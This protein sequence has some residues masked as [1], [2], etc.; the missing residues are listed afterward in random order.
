MSL[1]ISMHR[2]VSS[3]DSNGFTSF[4][5]CIPFFFFSF[6]SLIVMARTSETRLNNN[7]KSGNPCLVLDLRWDAFSVSPM[8]MFAMGLLYMAFMMLR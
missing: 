4:R 8:R 6:S 5:L 3:A 1:G 7:G 2:I